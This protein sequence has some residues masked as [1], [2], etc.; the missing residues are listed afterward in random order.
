MRQIDPD[1]LLGR[2]V[3]RLRPVILKAA[4]AVPA[5][6]AGARHL[7]LTS[8]RGSVDPVDKRFYL[9]RG[10]A[11]ILDGEILIERQRAVLARP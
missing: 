10:F 6:G 2:P 8:E 7:S 3:H 5:P 9:R 11:D 4:K 1:P